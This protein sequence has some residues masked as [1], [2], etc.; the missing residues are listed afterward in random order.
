MRRKAAAAAAAVAVW[1]SARIDVVQE[2]RR[3]AV[4]GERSAGGRAL[5][6]RAQAPAIAD[7]CSVQQGSRL[8]SERGCAAAVRA[9]AWRARKCSRA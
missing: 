9:A 1:P 8:C 3:A 2:V 7:C 5:A 4:G 6:D